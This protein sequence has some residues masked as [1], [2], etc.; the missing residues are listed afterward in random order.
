[1]KTKTH[2]TNR[3]G[4]V[5]ESLL[6]HIWTNT[7]QKV[8]RTKQ[9]EVASSDHQLVW[10]ERTTQQLVER[11]KR[12]EKRSK[13]NFRLEDLEEMCRR[14]HW[15]Y[16][17]TEER[18]ESVLETR[19]AQLEEKIQNILEKVAPLKTKTLT[20]V[21]YSRNAGEKKRKSQ[22]QKEGLKVGKD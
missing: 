21:A 2:P 4:I 7:P 8:A 10:V 17:G 22:A 6:D 18:N 1:M 11:V 15:K 16:E 13:L 19:V 20:Q 12:I 5:S 9:D 14:E 3:E